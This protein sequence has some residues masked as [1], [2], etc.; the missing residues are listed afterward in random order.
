MTSQPHASNLHRVELEFEDGIYGKLICPESGC[1]PATVCA[2]CGRDVATDEGERCYDCPEPGD[3]AECW[4]KTWFDNLSVSELLRGSLTIEVDC[5]WDGD[6]MT[7][8]V[9][10]AVEPAEAK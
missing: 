5:S 6:T 3:A 7:A 10:R 9:V 1:Q 2:S 4:I 8:E